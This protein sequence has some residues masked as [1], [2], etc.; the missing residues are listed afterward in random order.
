MWFP[1]PDMCP[2]AIRESL[3]LYARLGVPPG[4]FLRA[5]LENSLKEAVGRADHINGP[6]IH[7]IVSYCYNELPS[8]CWGSPERVARWIE[9]KKVLGQR[10]EASGG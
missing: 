6:A 5:V 8:T 9:D 3:D 1:D 4:D 10:R 7:H 2:L